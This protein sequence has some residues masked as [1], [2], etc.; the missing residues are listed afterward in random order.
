MIDLKTVKRRADAASA[1]RGVLAEQVARE[2]SEL[3]TAERRE[4]VLLKAQKV[5]QEVAEA[6]QRQAHRRISSV[7]TRCLEAVFGD[8]AYEF[9]VKFAQKRGRTEAE[10]VFCRGGVEVDPLTASG[11]GAVDVASLALRLACLRLARPKLR[12]FLSL[13]E[14][15]RFLSRD[16]VGRAGKLLQALCDEGLQ[17]LMV[18]HN[19]RLAVGKV[20]E[21]E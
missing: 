9:Q 5:V 14:P 8:D 18:T 3:A 10:L 1:R 20:V 16:Y 2:A 13:D 17:V 12:Q 6:V 21:V 19:R 4:A 7:V 11:G 15:L